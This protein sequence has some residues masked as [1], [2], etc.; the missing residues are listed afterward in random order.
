[1][2][3]RDVCIK[4][5]DLETFNNKYDT[6]IDRNMAMYSL[7]SQLEKI[8]T[9]SCGYVTKTEDR[10]LKAVLKS[11]NEYIINIEDVFYLCVRDVEVSKEA[12]N[13]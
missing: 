6:V 11:M 1:M 9:I 7:F 12:N 4:N 13:E 5:I 8:S 3:R 10:A 2:N